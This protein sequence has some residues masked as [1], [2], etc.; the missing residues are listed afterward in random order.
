MPLDLVPEHKELIFIKGLYLLDAETKIVLPGTAG[1]QAAAAA[2]QLQAEI[3][4]AAGLDLPVVEA[5]APSGR[6][7][8]IL[9]LCGKD[10]AAAVG[11]EPAQIGAPLEVTSQAYVLTIERGRIVLY[12]PQASGLIRGVLTLCQ[13]VRSQGAALPTLGLR[14]WPS[15]EE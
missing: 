8:V 4:A 15:S 1:M 9:L 2:G 7:N 3:R 5:V 12:A 13:I 14:D 6:L 10:E 11:L